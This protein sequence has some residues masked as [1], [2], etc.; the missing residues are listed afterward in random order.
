MTNSLRALLEGLIDYAGIFPPAGLPVAEAVRNFAHYRGEPDAWMLARFVFPA[1]RLPELDG[2]AA[3][4]F[5]AETPL[6]VSALGTSGEDANSALSALGDDLAAIHAFRDQHRERVVVDAIETRLP[7]SLASASDPAALRAYLVAADDAIQAGSPAPV[8]VFHE[9]PLAADWSAQ[10]PRVAGALAAAGCAAGFKLR[11]GGLEASAFPSSL[12]VATMIDACRRAGVA[13][14]ATAGLHHPLRHLNAALETH[15]HGFLNVFGGAA[16]AAAH[17]LDAAA[18]ARILAE[19]D[20]AAFRFDG[21]TLGWRELSAP[22]TA[23]I[24]AR[25]TLAI[26]FGSCSFD[27]PREDL[28]ALG[29]LP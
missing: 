17:D 29:L 2:F 8:T 20:P 26:S 1:R 21:D 6:A 10:I 22:V 4:L 18:L 11:T 16:L 14:K 7:S 28:A 5:T 25:R 15:M 12:Q 24:E 23:V 13:F 27:E 9:T 19:E 3:T